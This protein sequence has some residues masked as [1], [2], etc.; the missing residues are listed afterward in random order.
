[1]SLSLTFGPPGSDV[2]V[3]A[4]GF[5]PGT[6]VGILFGGQEV[7]TATAKPGTG[8]ALGA[9][10]LAVLRPERLL[11][12]VGLAQADAVGGIEETIKVPD[13]S[14]GMY[15]VC[16]S[17]RETET[18]CAA[19]RVTERASVAG[20]SFSRGD[21][22]VRVLGRTFARTGASIAL[23]V[24]LAVGFLLLGRSLRAAGRRRRARA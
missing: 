15:D 22:G 5:T 20:V 19:F 6:P 7:R 12:A 4:S 11:A 9:S 23:L 21:D 13:V 17:S 14:P 1:M 18:V 3:V 8:T 10:G 2:E 24:A 16:V